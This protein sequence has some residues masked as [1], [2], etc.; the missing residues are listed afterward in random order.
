MKVLKMR[1]EPTFWVYFLWSFWRPWSK[2]SIPSVSIASF[3]TNECLEQAAWMPTSWRLLYLR[4]CFLKGSAVWATSSSQ[5]PIFELVSFCLFSCFI[6]WAI[7]FI[8]CFHLSGC[9]NLDSHCGV[10]MIFCPLETLTHN[11]V[12]GS[13]DFA[14]LSFAC[15][16]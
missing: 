9:I 1:P 5:L 3:F 16:H 8:C 11:E 12:V 13:S 14:G 2:L 7:S 4:A 15:I 10:W 6:Q